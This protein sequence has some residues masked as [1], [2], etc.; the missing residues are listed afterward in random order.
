L[1]QKQLFLLGKCASVDE[2]A[3]RFQGSYKDKKRIT[4]KAEGD[5][6]QCDALCQEGF[7]YQ[8]Y[9]RNDPAPKKYLALGL[10]LLLHARVMWLFDSLLDDHHQIGMDNLYNSAAFCSA[11]FLH[12]RKV[13][14]HGVVRKRGRGAPKC[15]IQE[16]VTDQKR[17]NCS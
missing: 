17:T 2:M 13:L 12:L 9:F 4:Y 1:D 3:I 5:G 7:C 8:H 14:Y 6:F 11:A 15:I 16:E 10:S